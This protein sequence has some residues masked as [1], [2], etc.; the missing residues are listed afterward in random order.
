MYQEVTV[1]A[2]DQDHTEHPTSPSATVQLLDLEPTITSEPTIEAEHST[3]LPP[4]HPEVTLAHSN[5]TQVSSHYGPGT[6]CNWC[7]QCGVEPSPTKQ[8]TPTQSP[9]PTKEV[10]I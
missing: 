9:E 6:Y 5:I 7:I 2:P 8:E 3:A 4:K 1:P 10:V